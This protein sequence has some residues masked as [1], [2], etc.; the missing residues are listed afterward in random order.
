MSGHKVTHVPYQILEKQHRVQQRLRMT[1]GTERRKV[2]TPLKLEHLP[3]AKG[4]KTLRPSLDISK[5]E[6]KCCV[7]RFVMNFLQGTQL[8][9][10]AEL[11]RGD[12]YL[13][14]RVIGPTRRQ[15]WESILKCSLHADS[16]KFAG[17]DAIAGTGSGRVVLETTT[18]T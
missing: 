11:V 14:V 1:L 13:R 10:K 7:G 6:N 17:P 8:G 18:S 12:V 4:A 3:F 16:T 9:P 5:N 2:T 15:G